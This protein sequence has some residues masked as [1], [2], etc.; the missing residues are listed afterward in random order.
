M[1]FRHR[2]SEFLEEWLYAWPNG[3]K[4][5]WFERENHTFKFGEN[6]KGENKIIEEVT[7]PNALF[8]S[9]AVQH[10]HPQLE[11]IFSWFRSFQVI[12]MTR[13]SLSSVSF[14]ISSEIRTGST[15]RRGCRPTD[16]VSGG[17]IAE[18][19]LGAFSQSVE[20]GGY[21]DCGLA[22]RTNKVGR[23]TPP[24]WSKFLL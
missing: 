10:N 13:R 4:Q 9:A 22:G 3:K 19:T 24:S 8:L 6:L 1:A 23:Q 11:S 2:T 17:R 20:E 5:V 16:I 7:R 18:T 15:V 21:W 12:N 14:R